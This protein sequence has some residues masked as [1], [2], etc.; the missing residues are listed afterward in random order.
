MRSG[1]HSPSFYSWVFMLFDEA[2]SPCVIRGVG[3]FGQGAYVCLLY[4]SGIADRLFQKGR[5]RRPPPI[6]GAS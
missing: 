2:A 1:E 5:L 6:A 4:F 3:R